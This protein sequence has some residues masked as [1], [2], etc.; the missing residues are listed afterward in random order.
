MAYDPVVSSIV[1]FQKDPTKL[2]G[3]VSVVGI[4]F[5]NTSVITVPQ[6]SITALQ[7]TNPWQV[8]VPSP[9][10]IAYQLAGSVLAVSGSF[11]AGNTSVSAFIESTNTSIFA[12]VKNSSIAVLQGTTPWLVN[13][14]SPSIT[15]YQAAGSVLAV[16]GSFTSGNTSVTTFPGN[17]TWITSVVNTNP[18]SLMVGASI[19]GITPVTLNAYNITDLPVKQSGAWV[20]SLVS[21]IPSSVQVGASVMGTVPVTQTTS[22]WVINMPS[23]SVIAY[24]A[25]GSIMA[26]SGSFSAGNTSVSGFIESTNTSIF[27]VVKNSSIAVLQ[28]T[29]PWVVNVPTSSYIAYQLA[30]SVMQV[31]G[32][33][34]GT[35]YVENNAVTA[36]VTGNAILYKKDETNSVLSAVS[37]QHPLPVQGSITALQGTSPWIVNMPSPSVVAIQSAG[38]VMGVRTDSASII[39]VLSLSSVAVLQGTNPWQ[40][41][42]PSPSVLLGSSNASVLLINEVTRND[43]VASLLGIDK[44]T[45]LMMGDSQ[46]R[47]VIKP[48]A[49]EDATI[50][51][52]T[53]SVVSTSVTLIQASVIGSRSYITD[54]WVANTGSVAALVTFQGGDTSLVGFTIAPATGGS[55]S[56]G[57][58]IPLKTTLSQ[59]LAFKGGTSTSILYVTVKGYQ[60]P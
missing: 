20:T 11:S 8:N 48:F 24:Q 50:I 53:G 21:T 39:A 13:M 9:S 49:P 38:S 60:A 54:F 35:Q 14:P 23:P 34:G 17:A 22:P 46:G 25:A 31:T 40:V 44:T 37:P 43:T 2:V 52:Y 56:P 29:N 3:T 33:G 5:G 47:T 19:I 45:R 27:T 6:G 28:G 41:N 7:G 1:V 58:A 15:V 59:D 12:V 16:S 32:G 51:S 55:N 36:S 18:S 26:I 42:M 10:T 4:N 57:I 30:G